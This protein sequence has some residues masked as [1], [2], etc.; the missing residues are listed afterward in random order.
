[1]KIKTNTDTLYQDDRGPKPFTFDYAVTQVFDDM[2]HRSIPNY[3][4]NLQTIVHLAKQYSREHT[5]CYDLGCSLGKLSIALSQAEL[6]CEKIVAIDQSTD[7]ISASQENLTKHKITTPIE[8]MVADLN[9]QE[10]QQKIAAT[11]SCV[12]ILNYTLQFLHPSHRLS[13]LQHV[14]K[15]LSFTDGG[16]LILCEKTR[17]ASTSAQQLLDHLYYNFKRQQ[18]YHHLEI[19]QKREALENVLRCDSVFEHQQRLTQA[20]F[21][22]YEIWHKHW[23]FT[24]W[25]AWT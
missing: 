15:S 20:G 6:P 16:I 7:M 13:L 4:N 5:V 12:I 10:V 2:V 3:A 19:S 9:A 1:M 8:F 21:S 17:P 23:H 14:H 11:P 24:A 25:I 18:G 22:S